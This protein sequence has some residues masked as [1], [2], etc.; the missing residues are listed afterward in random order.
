MPVRIKEAK[1]KEKIPAPPPGRTLIAINA[2][3][4]T[5]KNGT[6]YAKLNVGYVDAIIAAGGLLVELLFLA[7]TAVVPGT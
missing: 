2:D 5:P 1:P 3:L 6:A 7:A 4:V